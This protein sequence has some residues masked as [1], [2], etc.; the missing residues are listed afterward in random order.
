[1]ADLQEELG[2]KAALIQELEDTLTE[3]QRVA[4]VIDQDVSC[5]PVSAVLDCLRL[6]PSWWPRCLTAML[7][8]RKHDSER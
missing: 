3:V 6:M 1:M 8:F 2:D 4:T 5:P 7:G